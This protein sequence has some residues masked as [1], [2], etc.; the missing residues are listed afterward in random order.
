[1]ASH[2]G[3]PPRCSAEMTYQSRMLKSQ[4]CG[5]A[6]GAVGLGLGIDGGGLNVADQHDP[7]DNAASGEAWDPT[8]D[9]GA[10]DDAV[11]DECIAREERE[12]VVARID[13]AAQPSVVTLE[14]ELSP[15]LSAQ[16]IARLTEQSELATA[17][18]DAARAI[19]AIANSI[20]V[21]ERLASHLSV[22]E[23]NRQMVLRIRDGRAALGALESVTAHHNGEAALTLFN[24]LR[25]ATAALNRKGDSQAEQRNGELLALA[26]ARRDDRVV[27][28]DDEQLLA[29][30]YE[31]AQPEAANPTSELGKFQR[32]SG[33]QTLTPSR[34]AALLGSI[35][36]VSINTG[37][38]KGMARAE[39]ERNAHFLPPCEGTREVPSSE[40]T[41]D[42]TIRPCNTV[43]VG[44]QSERSSS[45]TGRHPSRR[46][47]G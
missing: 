36:D 31:I 28:Y 3:R 41:I 20:A 19:S 27:G 9:N 16:L 8:R 42:A 13:D 33:V 29:V 39:A 34:K 44:S 21:G 18:P 7:A 30:L 32:A 23:A 47:A 4:R 45:G 43:N 5:T 25:G 37:L 35:L 15:E 12:R 10:A 38:V 14:R 6:S 2:S 11:I 1:M 17:Y 22:E 26:W 24:H 40:Q 46:S